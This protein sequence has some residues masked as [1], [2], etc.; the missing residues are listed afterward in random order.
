MT[1]IWCMRRRFG[2]CLFEYDYHNLEC[3]WL[4]LRN[5]A[6]KHLLIKNSL[7]LLLQ[8]VLYPLSSA[9]ILDSSGCCLITG[10]ASASK[11]C[12][13]SMFLLLICSTLW[14]WVS[15]LSAT[16][17]LNWKARIQL[18]TEYWISGFK[19]IWIIPMPSWFANWRILTVTK[20]IRSSIHHYFL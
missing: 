19:C 4:S 8:S 15:C 3:D 11:H 12:A 20:E 10:C 18:S 16:G 5:K 17:L 6:V 7:E 2:G 13:W 9:Q 14:F 1:P